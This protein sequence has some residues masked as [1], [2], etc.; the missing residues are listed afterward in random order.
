[1]ELRLSDAV[2]T[3]R[4]ELNQAAEQ[5]KDQDLT[6]RV[7]PIQME[8]EIQFR[9]D[10]KAKAGFA[11]WIATGEV[12]A[13]AGRTSTHKVAFTLAPHNADHPTGDVAINS[14]REHSNPEPVAPPP[15]TR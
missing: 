11:A 5:A 4:D 8:F 15:F 3:L 9:A 12:E 10:A 1:M 2:Q 7:G 13:G 6:F 14:A